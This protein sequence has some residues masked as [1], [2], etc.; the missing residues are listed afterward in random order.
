M[1]YPRLCLALFATLAVSHLPSQASARCA[2]QFVRQWPELDARGVPTDTSILLVF[3]DTQGVTG[4]LGRVELAAGGDRVPLR[5]AFD[6]IGG[7]G[8]R[9]QRTIALVPERPLRAN[10]RYQIRGTLIAGRR[11]P[12]RFTT[13]RTAIGAAPALASVRTGAFSSTEYGCGPAQAIPIEL[14]ITNRAAG[15]A[16][17]RIRLARSAADLAAG[18]LAGDVLVEIEGNTASFGHGMCFGAWPLE[19]GDRFVATVAVV[20]GAFAESTPSAPL[21]LEAR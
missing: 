2:G 21:V 9:A 16:F 17:A 15:P 12:V 1:T 11:M 19:P 18:R 6:Q 20:N 7:D 4:P 13:G 3:G 10:A 8:F 14:S 5:V